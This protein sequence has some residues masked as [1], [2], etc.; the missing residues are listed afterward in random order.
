MGRAEQRLLHPPY[1]PK[2]GFNGQVH[3]MTW[4][5]AR[6]RLLSLLAWSGR[7]PEEIAIPAVLVLMQERRTAFLLEF[8]HE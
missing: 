8:M 6:N 1:V 4:S 2:V 3:S 5:E 7:L